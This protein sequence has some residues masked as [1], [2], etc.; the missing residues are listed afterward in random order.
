MANRCGQVGLFCCHDEKKILPSSHDDGLYNL[1]R[2]ADRASSPSYGLRRDESHT[3][4]CLPCEESKIRPA[5]HS[6][7]D[8]NANI[9]KEMRSWRYQS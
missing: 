1:A 6:S 7:S 9:A 5:R 4:L 3:K 2:K 8:Q